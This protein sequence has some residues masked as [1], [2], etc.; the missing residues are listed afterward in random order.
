MQP[1]PAAGRDVSERLADAWRGWAQ[2]HLALVRRC[3]LAWTVWCW[4]S[5][6]AGLV[7]LLLV[8]STRRGLPAALWMYYPLVQMWL[9]C[10]SKTLTWRAYSSAFVAGLVL[11]PLIGLADNLVADAF[12]WPLPDPRATVWV[13]GPVE[14][15]LKLAPLFAVLVLARHRAARLAVVDFLLLAAAGG[16]AFQY[17][18]DVIRR[19]LYRPSLL[20]L[21]LSGDNTATQYEVVALF[22]GWMESADGER[23][24]GHA[25]TS[26]LI[27]VGIGLAA[28]LR[29]RLGRRVWALPVGLWLIQ[30][31]AHTLYNNAAVGG[32]GIVPG[33]L[34]GLYT[35]W[36]SGHLERPLLVVLIVAALAVDYRAIHS[37]AVRLPALPGTNL[38]GPVTGFTS[39]TALRLGAAVPPD[40]APV[41]RRTAEAMGQAWAVLGVTAAAVWHECV[42]LVVAASKGPATWFSSIVVLRE[43]RELGVALAREAT[44][45]RPPRDPDA[46][47]QR[48]VQLRAAMAVLAVLAL[49]ATAAAAELLPVQ[50]GPPAFLAGLFDQLGQWW[51]SLPLW[52]QLLVV[53]GAAALL[54]L[55]GMGFL[56]ALSVVSTVSSVAGHGQG[57]ATFL[58]DPRQATRD[59]LTNLTPAQ[60]ASIGVGLVLERVLPAAAGGL[61]GRT[62]RTTIRRAADDLADD[63]DEAV[64]QAADTLSVD[65]ALIRA[66]RQQELAM[67]PATGRVTP[68]SLQEAH[69]GLALEEAGRLPGPVTREPT[70]AG[71][72]VDG[73]GR[74]YDVKGFQDTHPGPGSFTPEAAESNLS[75]KLTQHPNFGI[76]LDVTRLQP[77]NQ[78]A[79]RQVVAQNGWTDLVLW[80]P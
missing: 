45:P 64:E 47:A 13:S 16:A 71:D 12:G 3:R 14:E 60:A 9:L 74:V 33:W 19:L 2:R 67:D 79:L 48:A 78:E 24:A 10:R 15:T 37:V 6:V 20:S 61:L 51:N 39:R 58:R 21:L 35:L 36:G 42:V 54:T 70:G 73:N 68:G 66:R 27:G 69:V 18:E 5:L 30:A 75:R 77:A 43:R 8:P 17:V 7:M 4:T 52:Q 40:A 63:A 34:Q 32:Q 65:D 76:I 44:L 11:A 26:A 1:V 53:G 23:F 38:A 55:G 25:V 46:T 49:V 22:P 56:P 31:L 28:R 50:V 29:S 62:G 41:F 80:W 72:L 57:I 59:F